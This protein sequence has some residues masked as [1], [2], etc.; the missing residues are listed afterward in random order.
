MLTE[1]KKKKKNF[2]QR[3]A[4]GLTGL[5]YIDKYYLGAKFIYIVRY[6]LEMKSICLG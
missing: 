2:L 4:E 6:F 3:K 1:F 5:S